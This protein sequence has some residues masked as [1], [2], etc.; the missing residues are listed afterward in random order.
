M[1]T[2]GWNFAFDDTPGVLLLNLRSYVNAC[3]YLILDA[4]TR[5]VPRFSLRRISRSRMTERGLHKV[6]F[7]S[8][9]HCGACRRESVRVQG[10]SVKGVSRVCVCVLSLVFVFHLLNVLSRSEIVLQSTGTRR[11]QRLRLSLRSFVLDRL[12]IP[13]EHGRGMCW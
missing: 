9:F 11:F 10:F 4:S 12:W 2:G 5:S 8:S 13:G 7:S 3:H 6:L 1:E